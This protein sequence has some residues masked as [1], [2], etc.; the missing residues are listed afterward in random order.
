[1]AWSAAPEW[2]RPETIQRWPGVPGNSLADSVGTVLAYNR[3]SGELDTWGFTA[4]PYNPDFRIEK[5]F[6]LFLD[7]EYRPES[8]HGNDP[9]LEQARQWYLDY[10]ACLYQWISRYFSEIVPRWWIRKVEYVFSV[11]GS[12]QDPEVIET[13]RRL[14]KMAGFGKELNHRADITLTEAEA[15]AVYVGPNK[16]KDGDVVLVCDSGAIATSL[17]IM[18]V[19]SLGFGQKGFEILS[20]VIGKAIGYSL[21]DFRVETFLRERLEI[22]RQHLTAEPQIMADRMMKQGRFESFKSSYGEEQTMQLDLPL[23]IPNMPFGQDF[24]LAGIV[25]SKILITR[26]DLQKF[27]D[28]EVN[29]LYRLIDRQLRELQQS[30]PSASI[31]YFVL[32]G[33]FG[34][35]A[36]VL[37]Q[38]QSHYQRDGRVLPNARKISVLHA[39]KPQLAIVHGLVM[40]RVQ[41]AKIKHITSLGNAGTANRLTREDQVVET[42]LRLRRR[43]STSTISTIDSPI[44]PYGVTETP[45]RLTLEDQVHGA[46][47]GL[48][49]RN[50]T[51]TMNSVN[52]PPPPYGLVDPASP[53]N[54]YQRRTRPRQSSTTTTFVSILF[55]RFR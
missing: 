8:S 30:H 9:S 13:L 18:K 41:K 29:A 32:T 3:R 11:P 17:D 31:T 44:F 27:F 34:H 21:I 36:Y 43:T 14:I 40:D 51:S 1:V 38:L 15:A 22:I 20:S 26:A 35:S 47:P 42:P 2:A 53:E 24:P 6:K 5:N 33:E 54:D 7:P 10:L 28:Q 23:Q 37:K 48:R 49:R 12:W 45:S 55:R 52:S 25:D 46:L 50:S 39:P 19:I 16:Y 4:D